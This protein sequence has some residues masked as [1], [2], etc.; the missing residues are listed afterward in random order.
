MALT[1]PENPRL[2]GTKITRLDGLAKASGRAK[3]PSDTR[4]EGTLFAVM[5]YSPHA[6]AKIK[7]ID[8]AAAEKMPGVKAVSTIAAAGTT[9]RYQGDDIAAVAAETEE[10]GA[11]RSAPSRSSTRCCH[12]WSPSIRPWPKGRPRSSRAGTSGKA[13]PRPRGNPRRPWARPTW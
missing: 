11:T 10:Q 3:Y 13:V 9:L 4:P 1:W 2:I 8:T 7:S 12:M 6:H 5:L